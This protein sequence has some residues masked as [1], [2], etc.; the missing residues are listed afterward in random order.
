ME[1]KLPRFQGRQQPQHWLFPGSMHP[2]LSLQVFL[3][4]TQE[5]QG[6]FAQWIKPDVPVVFFESPQ[7]LEMPCRSHGGIPC[8]SGQFVPRDDQGIRRCNN[9]PGAGDL[10]PDANSGFKANGLLLPTWILVKIKR[11]QRLRLLIRFL[12][13]HSPD[14]VLCYGLGLYYICMQPG[15]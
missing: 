9:R 2:S 5:R 6:F 8:N 10:C 11:R 3:L 1:S 4:E 7:A 14:Y 15:A 13:E 12:V